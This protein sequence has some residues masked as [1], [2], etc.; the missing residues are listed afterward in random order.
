MN[1]SSNETNEKRVSL[2]TSP[3]G[4]TGG[5]SQHPAKDSDLGMWLP[6]TFVWHITWGSVGHGTSEL[7]YAAMSQ[8]GL[9]MK[10]KEKLCG[11]YTLKLG[12]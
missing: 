7:P 11:G 8:G 1:D 12:W 2:S 6:P 4:P 10:P 5:K 9:V 3:E